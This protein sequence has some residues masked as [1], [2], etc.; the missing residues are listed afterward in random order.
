M[1]RSEAVSTIAS[2]LALA[3]CGARPPLPSCH[4]PP[5]AAPQ[6]P[7][8]A[9]ER[10]LAAFADGDVAAWHGADGCRRA[11]ADH[12]FGATGA[13]DAAVGPLG[14]WQ[15]YGAQRGAPWGIDVRYAPDRTTIDVIEIA[16]PRVV[17]PWRRGLGAP[18]ATEPSHHFDYGTQYIYASRGLTVHEEPDGPVIG[19]VAYRPMTVEQFQSS[20]LGLAFA[21]IEDPVNRVDERQR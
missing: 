15:H 3:G 5:A 4:A 17:Q 1:K 2:V 19:V 7:V 6:P 13:C 9:C 12:V 21:A 14:G 16:E 8:T 18:E 11:D 10:A 20:E